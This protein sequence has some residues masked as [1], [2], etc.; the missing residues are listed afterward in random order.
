MRAV[1]SRAASLALVTAIVEAVAPGASTTPFLP[2]DT[3]IHCQPPR[4]GQVYFT[5]FRQF[6]APVGAKGAALVDRIADG[7][8]RRGFRMRTAYRAGSGLVRSGQ[9]RFEGVLIRGEAQRRTVTIT[10]DTACGPP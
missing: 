4:Q 5:L 10:L 6:D 2:D 8:A 3:P 7:F 1:D 9:T